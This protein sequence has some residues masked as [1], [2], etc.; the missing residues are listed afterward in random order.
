MFARL[1]EEGA[2]PTRCIL[3][4]VHQYC[5]PSLIL[6]WIRDLVPLVSIQEFLD[7]SIEVV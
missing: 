4:R 6:S 3:A 1:G 7:L 2:L 5:T